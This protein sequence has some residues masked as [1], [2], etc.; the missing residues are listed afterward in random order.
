MLPVVPELAPHPII[1]FLKVAILRR[2]LRYFQ[3]YELTAWGYLG[4]EQAY[5]PLPRLGVQYRISLERRA[6]SMD[7]V[8]SL[9]ASVNDPPRRRDQTHHHITAWPA[10]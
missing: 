10:R 1:G 5:C 3:S 9:G 2:R 8:C 4:P 7:N 6:G